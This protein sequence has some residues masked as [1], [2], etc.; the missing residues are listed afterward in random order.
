MVV[1]WL[2]VVA[3]L[4]PMTKRLA[5]KVVESKFEEELE[6]TKSALRIQEEA[7]KSELQG[8]LNELTALQGPAFAALTHRR[9]A[10]DKRTLEAVDTLWD[11][12]NRIASY[13]AAAGFMSRIK[14]PESAAHAAQNPNA[15]AAFEQ[16]YKMTGI[17]NLERSDARSA[18]PYVS[19]T[20]WALYSAYQ[21]IGSY[22]VL[23]LIILKSGMK[24]TD[25]LKTREVVE[26]A[27][28]AL[29]HYR[30][31]LEEH[32]MQGAYLL[33]EELEEKLLSELQRM[34][35]EDGSAEDL[36]AASKILSM[37]TE[38]AAAANSTTREAGL[39]TAS[40]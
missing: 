35:K 33:L 29:P 16:M 13:K 6:R 4:L 3:I 32:G 38:L 26:L 5:T 34:L 20:A 11:A 37:S 1:L 36:E 19:A 39:G 18:R 23:A 24:N 7:W 8:K 22:A 14:F 9:A 25:V 21:A 31:F 40:A 27:Q 2:L 30:G 12:V 28:A 17:E 10:L 15:R